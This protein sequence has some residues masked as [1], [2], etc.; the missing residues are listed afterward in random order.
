MIPAS[1]TERNRL[2]ATITGLTHGGLA[3]FLTSKK[4]E[5][6]TMPHPEADES[7]AM[8]EEMRKMQGLMI[9][10]AA[11]AGHQQAQAMLAQGRS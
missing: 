4:N 10:R 1:G 2:F 9:A 7:F 8:R 11:A 5:P 3:Y 6:K